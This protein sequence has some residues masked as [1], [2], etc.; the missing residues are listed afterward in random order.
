MKCLACGVRGRA[1]CT[2]CFEAVPTAETKEDE[3]SADEPGICGTMSEAV[4]E[5]A[6]GE[7]VSED[8]LWK[9]RGRSTK[10]IN[11][12]GGYL[13]DTPKMYD[14]VA[15]LRQRLSGIVCFFFV[16]FFY[17]SF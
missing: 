2:H 5:K 6:I 1:D 16:A 11:R 14:R 4:Y 12:H 9:A 8:G 17:D 13:R 15:W 3:V 7:R 10:P